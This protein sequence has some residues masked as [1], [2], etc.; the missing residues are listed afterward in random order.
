MAKNT[1]VSKKERECYDLSLDYVHKILKSIDEEDINKEK[2]DLCKL[3]I[4][5]FNGEANEESE[6]MAELFDLAN[7]LMTNAPDYVRQE[8]IK[9]LKQKNKINT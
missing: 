4:S 1:T 7:N 6:E 9:A 5:K 8:S 2:L 3:C